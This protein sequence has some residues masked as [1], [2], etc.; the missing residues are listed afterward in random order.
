MTALSPRPQ[1]DLAQSAHDITL[2]E[3]VAGLDSRG[4]RPIALSVR[5]VCF[6]YDA[7]AGINKTP[8]LQ[9]LD[10]TVYAGDRV[11][12]IGCNGVGKTTLFHSICGVLTPASGDI[13]LFERL[14]QPGHFLPDVG[15]VFQDPNDQ[16]FSS[17]V[18]DDI[19]FGP[20]NMGL[21]DDDVHRRV[22]QA[23]QVT[24]TQSLAD[25]P[26]H[27]LSGG[28]KRMVAIASILAMQPKLTIFDE[29]SANL[30]CRSRRRLIHFL[31]EMSHTILLASHDLE[32]VLEVCDRV[33]ILDGGQVVADG[34]VRQVMANRDIMEYHGLEC[35]HSLTHTHTYPAQNASQNAVH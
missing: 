33:V 25:R 4:A 6:D 17:R 24:G 11:G 35:P 29:P 31:Q 3:V 14:V 5:D 7:G 30:D 12:V 2:S 21:T 27:Q 22:E 32:L 23:M 18:W 16:L 28:Q 9:H 20:Q 15:L 34:P 1:S 10:L 19:A 26:P 8:V 13:E